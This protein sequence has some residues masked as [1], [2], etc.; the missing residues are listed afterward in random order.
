MQYPFFPSQEKEKIKA[1]RAD[2]LMMEYS[3]EQWLEFVPKQAPRGV[4]PSPVPGYEYSMAWKWDPHTPNQIQC[5]ASGV[6]FPNEK[7]PPSFTSV[8]VLSGKTVEVPYWQTR[9]FRQTKAGI[10]LVQARIDCAKRHFLVE[11]L[12]LLA[13]RY[14]MTGD[15][16][17]A[18]RVAVT[19]DA[20]AN[21]VPDYYIT[22]GWNQLVPLSPEEAEKVGWVAERVST[23]NGFAHEL[24]TELIAAFDRI[25]H[26]Q[27]LDELSEERGY[28]VRTHIKN[29][30]FVNILDYL[31]E[32]IPMK[33]LLS[34]N[35]STPYVCAAQTAIL[36][37][38]PNVIEWL[39]KYLSVMIERNFM[40]DGMYPESFLY[41]KQYAVANYEVCRQIIRYFQTYPP[42][43]APMKAIEA[44]ME[45]RQAF[46]QKAIDAVD[47]VSFPD[48]D[49]APYSDSSMMIMVRFLSLLKL[50]DN[51]VLPSCDTPEGGAL[52]R[53]VTESQLL[54]SYGHLTLGSGS[55]HQQIQL[56][57]AFNDHANH[58]H[59]DTLSYTLFGFGRE[60]IG[61]IRY[62]KIPGRGFGIVSMGHNTVV[63]NQKTQYTGIRQEYGNEGHLFTG[64]NLTLFEP[65]LHGIAAAE[66]D[67]RWANPDTA[68]KYQRTVLLNTID[69]DH[70]Y[71]VD[72]FT[73]KGGQ[74]HDY[75]LHGSTKFEQTAQI[76]FD[77][78]P[79][80][81][82]HPLLGEEE[83]W[84]EPVHDSEAPN[85]YGMFREMSVGRSS[86]I[87]DMTLSDAETGQGHTRLFMVD[88]G[89]T[90]VYLGKS[91]APYRDRLP[92][93]FYDHWRP[94]LMVR[95]Q[96][97]GSEN[98]KSTFTGVLE[99]LNGESAI[100]RVEKLPLAEENADALALKVHFTSGR[101]D[102]YL[103][104][105]KNPEISAAGS[106][107]EVLRTS[108]GK[109]ALEG[110]IG[111]HSYSAEGARSYLI[112]GKSFDTPYKS[113][114]AEKSSY[115]GIIT[116][117]L[118]KEEGAFTDAFITEEILPEGHLL[119][120]RWLSF[121]YGSYSVIPD[122]HGNH[123]LGIK[124]QTGLSQPH[125]IRSIERV[126][127]K[128]YIH[129]MEDP[130]LSLQEEGVLE[131]M[132][133]HRKFIGDCTFK[134]NISASA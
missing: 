39:D 11:T 68:E 89:D 130:M 81:R 12:P 92:K 46:L 66:V 128:T 71:V 109:F 74:T 125:Q 83:E 55:G 115:S 96:S 2:S 42:S 54:P 3:E 94:S 61:D 62:S 5:A 51:V 8:K 80:R 27:A 112:V 101:E 17:F 121:L 1:V 111:I 41:H 48:G 131:L 95:H 14:E 134:I 32:K 105:L 122:S 82:E 26:S 23:H 72:L 70:P 21:Y 33:A 113:L 15:E 30:F 124:E 4:C 126:D 64:G 9:N 133:P 47:R 127:G 132:R 49:M 57:M 43:I 114:H 7:Y 100:C 119:E 19:F 53:Q 91:P 20:W 63:I 37:H 108:D 103:I 29:N 99:P 86:G 97:S 24:N 36:L 118:R 117:I 98:L 87:W 18:R 58:C 52:P 59:H 123:P 35:L 31:I 25:Y 45:Q 28:D 85:W 93:T 22:K 40:R 75:F 107:P 67:G 16:K 13:T 102:V 84:K 76:S 34:T 116:G 56:N 110:K 79:I 90:R 65:G 60:L 77:L 129:L 10:T 73:V 50:Y 120:G 44:R 104:H 38:R 78:E 6:I 106:V 69:P 88:D